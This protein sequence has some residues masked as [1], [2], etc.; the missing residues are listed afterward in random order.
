MKTKLEF[1]N[2]ALGFS[3]NAPV[4]VGA[5]LWRTPGPAGPSV[6]ASSLSS[7]PWAPRSTG[8][9]VCPLHRCGTP[10][11]GLWS[12]WGFCI[13]HTRLSSACGGTAVFGSTFGCDWKPGQ[14][15]CCWAAEAGL[16]S[17]EGACDSSWWFEV[18]RLWGERQEG[19]ESRDLLGEHDWAFFDLLD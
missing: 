17:S 1:V 14:Q 9:C 3:H 19:A 18:Q 7:L 12:S 5:P 13:W 8:A 2:V 11:C 16:S 10:A 15:Q 4:R 6:H